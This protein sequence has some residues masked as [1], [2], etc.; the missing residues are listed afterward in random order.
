MTDSAFDGAVGAVWDQAVAIQ[1]DTAQGVL[2]LLTDAAAQIDQLLARQPTDWQQWALPQLKKQIEQEMAAFGAAAGQTL[3]A[4]AEASFEA[5]IRLVDQPVAAGNGA[6][7]PGIVLQAHLP[8]LDRRQLMATQ[9]FLTAKMA[10]VSAATARRIDRELGLVVTGLATPSEAATAV[11]AALE[12]APRQRALTITRTELGRAFSAAAQGRMTQAT[13]SLPGLKKKWRRSGKIQSRH[14]HDLADGQVVDVDK[15]F[16]IGGEEMMYPRDPAASASNTVN[17]GCMVIPHMEHWRTSFPAE[18][19]F[20]TAELAASPEKRDI[21]E[22]RARAS[23]THLRS[24]A[25]GSGAQDLRWHSAPSPP[26]EAEDLVLRR[27]VLAAGSVEGA[28]G[29]HLAARDLRTGHVWP[30]VTSGERE[31]VDI[32][33]TLKDA[34]LDPTGQIVLHHNHPDSKSLSAQDLAVVLAHPGCAAAYAHGHDGTTYKVQPGPLGR[35]GDL[36]ALDMVAQTT[37]GRQLERQAMKGRLWPAEVAAYRR[38]AVNEA[39]ARAGVIDY[40]VAWSASAHTDWDM[41]KDAF[42]NAIAAGADMIRG[43]LRDA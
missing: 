19:P 3:G 5:G 12:G 21:K 31:R 7:E 43:H 2:D 39:L 16:V 40:T 20:T 10:D 28:I 35:R 14:T 26:L 4:G 36:R 9:T 30:V 42:E 22:V 6:A 11:Q 41:L 25:T 38:H 1:K 27:Q 17:C 23:Q 33:A 18:K 13:K 8:R 37:V 24:D 15:P 34:L 32:P 29:E